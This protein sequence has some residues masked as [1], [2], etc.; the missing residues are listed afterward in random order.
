MHVGEDWFSLMQLGSFLQLG[1]DGSWVQCGVDGFSMFQFSSTW[2]T[3][4]QSGLVCCNL[5]QGC[6]D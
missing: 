1:S 3:L 5:V 6:S 2:C 4:V